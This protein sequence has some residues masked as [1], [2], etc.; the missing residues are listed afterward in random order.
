MID[1]ND[2]VPEIFTFSPANIQLINNSIIYVLEN[3]SLDTPILY[4]TVSDC[5]S[6]ENGRVTIELVSFSN[7]TSAIKLE[8]ITDHTCVLKTNIH[9]DREEKSFYQFQLMT[10]DHGQP[11]NLIENLFELHLI[12]INDCWPIFEN[13]TQYL[14]YINENN[15]ENFILHTFKVFDYDEDDHIK[16][17]L[18]F[19]NNEEY[20]FLFQ[21]NERNQL[22]ILKS[23]DYEKQTFYEF[24]ILAEDKIEHRTIVPIFIYIKDL[25]DNPVK[26]LTN[27]TQFQLEENQN[28]HTFIGH[29]Y[30]EDKDKTNQIIYQ[31]HSDD[32]NYINKFIDLN[33]ING[34]LF[35]RISFDRERI[36]KLK[37]RIIA[38]D[39]IHID[40]ILIEIFI[41][42]QN[43]NKPTIVTR[44]P[45]CLIYN[46]TNTKQS[47]SIHLEGY[48]L[49][50]NDNGNISFIMINPS[51]MNIKLLSNGT[52]IVPSLYEEYKFDLILKDHSKSNVLS[53]IYENFILLIVS[54]QT[55]CEN[56]SFLSSIRFNQR[57]FIYFISTILISLVCLT[58]IILI[59]YCFYYFRRRYTRMKLLNNKV[60]TNLT[61]SFSSSFNED[62][63]NDTLLLSSP[64]PQFTAMTTVSISTTTTNDSTRLK[65]FTDRTQTNK[66][67][68]L[69]SSSSTTYVKMSHSFEDEIL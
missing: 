19:N 24:S 49:D 43:D 33:N 3:I 38:N 63:E 5:D 56:Y 12:D 57:S 60:K 35:T 34:S 54:H 2:C 47:I 13:S 37:F 68:S 15:E 20:H 40:L 65:T 59:I 22:I 1:E 6:N 51:S 32:S 66:S 10:Y 29:I 27:Y 64:S 21:L 23:L 61:P 69:S 31:I 17:R 14:F 55:E 41:L 16:L 39:S 7:Q 52:L 62:V 58:L 8:K 48:D 45:L 28:N 18:L 26:F 9:L 11:K 44:S 46:R 42:D 50:A 4:V 30:A 67:S 25:N 36:D 53:S